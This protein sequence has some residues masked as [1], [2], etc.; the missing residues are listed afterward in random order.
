MLLVW[1]AHC[2][3]QLHSVVVTVLAASEQLH[4]FDLQALALLPPLFPDPDLHLSDR[5][6]A[7]AVCSDSPSLSFASADWA[8][9]PIAWRKGLAWQCD[10]RAR[11]AR[12]VKVPS[13][14][15][16]VLGG[17]LAW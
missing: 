5:R 2:R 6:N 14:S 4:V 3:L 16:R 15:L 9:K 1:M 7:G 8:S 10:Q 12:L 13:G 17:A 11:L